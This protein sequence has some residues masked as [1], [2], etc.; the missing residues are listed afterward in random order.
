MQ[1]KNYTSSTD[2]VEVKSELELR[3]MSFDEYFKF[4]QQFFVIYHL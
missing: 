2:I 3:Y 1:L 4:M